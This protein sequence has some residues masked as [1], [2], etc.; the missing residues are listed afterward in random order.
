MGGPSTGSTQRGGCPAYLSIATLAFAPGHCQRTLPLREVVREAGRE[1]EPSDRLIRGA[2]PAPRPV[3][4]P[5]SAGH[6][7][8]PRSF[9]GLNPRLLRTL[10]HPPSAARAGRRRPVD[11]PSEPRLPQPWREVTAALPDTRCAPGP[12]KGDG[13]RIREVLE[14]WKNGRISPRTLL[15]EFL[16]NWRTS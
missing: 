15:T 16:T 7:S 9:R 12:D 2:N 8:V 1:A 4:V 10:R 13:T 5:R 3:S 14:G 6:R 11:G